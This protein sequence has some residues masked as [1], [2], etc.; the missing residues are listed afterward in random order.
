MNESRQRVLNSPLMRLAFFFIG[1]VPVS[2]LVFLDCTFVLPAGFLI[3]AGSLP[4]QERLIG[5]LFFIWGLAGLAGGIS[6]FL[7]FFSLGVHDRSA[8]VQ[9]SW[10]IGG[11]IAASIISIWPFWELRSIYVLL[12]IW[13][14]LMG[15]LLLLMVWEAPYK[16]FAEVSNMPPNK[17]IEPTR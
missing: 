10:I 14:S 8:R 5:G 17:P 6:G 13:V 11:G 2:I 7:S 1:G 16:I 15:S 9:H 4:A 3:F 12:P